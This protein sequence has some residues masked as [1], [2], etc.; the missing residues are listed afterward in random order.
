MIEITKM[1]WKRTK[2]PELSIN[3][4]NKA[5]KKK[6]RMATIWKEPDKSK[7]TYR[8]SRLG[9]KLNKLTIPVL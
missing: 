4:K 1:N 7:N 9:S 8:Q 6:N 5:E 2:S 3:A